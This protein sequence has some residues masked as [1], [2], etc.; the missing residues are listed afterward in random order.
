[1]RPVDLYRMTNVRRPGLVLI[2]DALA[3]PAGSGLDKVL[4]DAARL[5]ARP[6]ENRR[7]RAEPRA[8]PDVTR[9]VHGT[10]AAVKTA[11]KFEAA[12]AGGARQMAGAAGSCAGL[13]KGSPT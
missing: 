11:P 5:F 9:N 12:G 1:M 3:R 4:S 13:I 8:Q 6:P 7:R 2:G 10:G